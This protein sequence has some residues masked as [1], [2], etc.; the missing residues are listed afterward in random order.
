VPPDATIRRFHSATLTETLYERTAGML[1]DPMG[2]R[3]VGTRI[4]FVTRWVKVGRV[5]PRAGIVIELSDRLEFNDM[6]ATKH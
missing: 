4:G 2:M 6:G 5:F 3:P 1:T